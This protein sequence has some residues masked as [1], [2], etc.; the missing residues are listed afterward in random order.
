[1]LNENILM[2]LPQNCYYGC[3]L[4]VF[5]QVYNSFIA[6]ILI[7]LLGPNVHVMQENIFNQPLLIY[8]LSNLKK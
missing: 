3:L 6:N 2:I 5:E 4:Y 1:M 8:I 7:F